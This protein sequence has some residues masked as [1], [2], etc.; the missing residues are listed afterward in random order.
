LIEHGF[1]KED[2]YF[3]SG[4]IDGKDLNKKIINLYN[5]DNKISIINYCNLSIL[6]NEGHV[7]L[8]IKNKK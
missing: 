2:N 4:I 7:E 1:E 3:I 8:W 6:G 5:N